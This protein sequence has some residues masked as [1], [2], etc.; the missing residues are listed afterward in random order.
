M[1]KNLNPQECYSHRSYRNI[2]LFSSNHQSSY[3][4]CS[5]K[6]DHAAGAAESASADSSNVTQDQL[7]TPRRKHLAAEAAESSIARKEL[8]AGRSR[9]RGDA[10]SR[11]RGRGKV[12]G[13]SVAWTPHL[14]R[15]NR[16]NQL[17]RTVNLSPLN[18]RAFGCCS[19]EY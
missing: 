9:R 14:A 11:G 3:D 7:A 16:R 10:R 17:L 2:Q 8:L 4:I 12:Y 1:Q 5:Y 13:F 15:K 19:H 6:Y 18:A